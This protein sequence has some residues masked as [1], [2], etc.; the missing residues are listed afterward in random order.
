MTWEFPGPPQAPSVCKFDTENEDFMTPMADIQ[1]LPLPAC[2]TSSKADALAQRR[3]R[4]GNMP[5]SAWVLSPRTPNSRFST[6]CGRACMDLYLSPV[7]MTSLPQKER[8]W[9]E[10]PQPNLTFIYSQESVVPMLSVPSY[11]RPDA[12]VPYLLKM[13]SAAKDN[14]A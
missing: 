5:I 2:H 14:A 9:P 3:A 1:P 4:V 11:P 6:A 12:Q 7:N 8:A 10:I 13:T